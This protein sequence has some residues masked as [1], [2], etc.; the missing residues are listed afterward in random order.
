MAK[1]L[2]AAG[3]ILED[4]AAS[5]RDGHLSLAFMD[6]P[7]YELFTTLSDETFAGLSQRTDLPLDLLML[8][9]E[10]AGG[11][12]PDPDDRIREDEPRTSSRRWRSSCP[13]RAS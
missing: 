4:L 9:R 10:A 7:T 12:I 1:T 3:V 8:I 6:G 11:A 13:T 5:I 2:E